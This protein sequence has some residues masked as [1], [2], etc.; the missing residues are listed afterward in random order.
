MVH[1]WK[2]FGADCEFATALRIT[3]C[4][5]HERTIRMSF[6]NTCWALSM[7][8]RIQQIRISVWRLKCQKSCTWLET[9]QIFTVCAGNFL[10][11][12]QHFTLVKFSC[13]CAAFYTREISCTLREVS[14]AWVQ[15]RWNVL[16]FAL[17]ELFVHVAQN[18]WLEKT[19]KKTFLYFALL[20]EACFQPTKET[21]F[22]Q[23]KS[24]A[25][26]IKVIQK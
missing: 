11:L 14:C 24:E 23:I 7:F 1:G 2:C 9:L 16:K 18:N 3:T 12:V 5:D 13:T 25:Y 19:T 26:S 4:S 17:K 6:T 8:W 22:L 20:Q 21:C 15:R 10:A